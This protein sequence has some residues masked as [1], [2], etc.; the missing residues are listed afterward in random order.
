M[1][2]GVYP[3][4]AAPTEAAAP[5]PVARPSLLP[6]R[7]DQANVVAEAGQAVLIW[8]ALFSVYGS[9][10]AV[11]YPDLLGITIAAAVWLV[12]LRCA[13]MPGRAVLGSGVAA[14][15]GTAAGLVVVTALN[16]SIVG[17][18]V[19]YPLLVGLGFAVFSSATVW[20]WFVDRTLA[21]RR[22]VLLV[23]AEGVENLVV[24]ELR[25]TRQRRFDVVGAVAGAEELAEIVEAQRPDLVV[26]TDET[27]YG[28]ALERLLDAR[29][30]VRVAG[31]ENFFEYAFGRVPVDQIT[32]A[33]FMS[34]LHP[35]QRMYT[36][37]TKRTFDVVVAVVLL[38]LT[39]PLIAL[40]ALAT[41]LRGGPV[42][43]RQTRLG[44]G[45][46]R[47]T[48]YKFRTMTC[49]AERDG[50]A[51]SPADDPRVTR[52][53][54]FLRRTHLDELP[55]LW[56]V[57]GGE[58]SVVGPRPERPEFIEM[59]EATV[60]FWNRR[61]LVKPGITG[62]AQVRCGYASNCL[63][64]E[65]KLSYDLWY[66]RNRSLLVDLAVCVLTVLAL[67]GRPVRP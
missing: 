23:G 34:L 46:R 11:S 45:G 19:S 15:V 8:F 29:A 28:P 51:F 66:L 32:P 24:E 57:L 10:H 49:D 4:V 13:V 62:W 39:A 30:R 38:V 48:I 3:D 6:L 58:M 27:T 60:P 2:E 25:A 31:I 22:R 50:A 67:V 37:F 61:L 63:D 16:S 44:E 7:V 21:A 54:K 59:I 65:T 17:L 47:F 36:R 1:T 35:R 43:Y 26:L 5:L 53:G 18:H 12:A 9:Q 56:N 33:W 52:V 20:G 41:K 14:S 64:M 55:Q 40:A 42:L